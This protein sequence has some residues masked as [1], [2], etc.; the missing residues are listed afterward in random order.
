MHITFVSAE[1]P[2]W[3]SGG[4]GTFL[5]T[6]GRAMVARGH[7]ITILGVG[8]DESEQLLDDEGVKI[9]RLPRNTSKLPNFLYNARHLNKRLQIIQQS[10][11]IDIIETAELGL[12]IISRN[13]PAKRVIRL[14]GGHHFFAEAEKRGINWRKGI[15]EKR[16]F[17]K[18]DGFIAVSGYVKSHTAKYLNY[19]GKPV[20]IINYPIDTDISPPSV[21]VNKDHILF[22]GTICEKKGVRQLLLAFYELRESF[23]EKILDLYGRDW[24]YPDGNSYIE[25]LKKTYDAA[26]F[27]NVHFHG[28]IP[29]EELDQRYAEASFC[30]FPSHMETQGLVTLEAMLLEKPVIFS[31]YG[32]GPETIEHGVTG[33]LCDV[34]DPADIT[35]KMK[36]IIENPVAA[37][38]MGRS[39]RQQV[40]KKY[41][42]NS[43]LDRNIAFYKSLIT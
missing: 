32:P 13:H 31:L 29:R 42:I 6:F 3:A 25:T 34:Y 26:Y 16:S 41:D 7:D 8:D 21:N 39:G 18:A 17:K 19:H 28:S 40:L 38:E 22:A 4:V 14:H 27:E 9:I 11:P 37:T 33:L 43:I 2:L 1:Y 20:Q 24:Y 30:I 10:R 35:L 5:Q 23:P 36:W 15:L 12:A